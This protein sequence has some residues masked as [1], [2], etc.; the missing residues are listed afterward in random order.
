LSSLAKLFELPLV[1]ER[2]EQVEKIKKAREQ[3]R[4]QVRGLGRGRGREEEKE[5]SY[6]NFR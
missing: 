5:E 2:R 3:G 6:I 1:R 4:G